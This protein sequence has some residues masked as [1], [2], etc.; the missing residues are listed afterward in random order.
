MSMVGLPLTGEGAWPSKSTG[1]WAV[2]LLTAIYIVS[3]I[4]RQIIVLLI[5]DIK[6][7][8]DLSDTRMAALHGVAFAVF[9]TLA[10]LPMGWLADRRSR[11]RLLTTCLGIWSLATALCAFAA[12]FEQLFL[13]RI[14]VAVNE[15]ALLPAAVSMIADLFS[16]ERRAQPMGVFN[17]AGGAGLGIALLLG[18]ALLAVAN[19][20][21]GSLPGT[22]AMHPWQLTFILVSLPGFLLMILMWTLREP[23]RRQVSSQSNAGFR[24]AQQFA[25]TRSAELFPIYLYFGAAAVMVLGMNSWA[26]TMLMRVHGWTAAEVGARLG[27]VTMIVS[28]LG[29]ALSGQFIGRLQRRGTMRASA[30]AMRLGAGIFIPSAI[31]APLM[32]NPIAATLLLGLF[33]FGLIFGSS[34]SMIALQQITPGTLRGLAI[35]ALFVV[36]NILGMGFGPIL[37]GLLTDRFFGDEAA[38]WASLSLT[39]AMVAPFPIYAAWRAL[40]RYR[41]APG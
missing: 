37:V 10:G 41:E 39:M 32:P 21:A 25:L 3:W 16:P 8:L 14:L 24:A 36:S 2:A 30:I 34:S 31:A 1:W 20:L 18:G 35:S 4:D 19:G 9:Y 28:A 38:I 6:E 29:G 26:P 7:A 27:I 5:P 15:A 11:K 33:N 22:E 12:N 40:P 17:A 23:A 13:L